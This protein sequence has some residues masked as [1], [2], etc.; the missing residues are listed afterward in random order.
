MCCQC[1]VY[2][3]EPPVL[4]A[5]RHIL[6]EREEQGFSE[7]ES[8][9]GFPGRLSGCVQMTPLTSRGRAEEKQACVV[10]SFGWVLVWVVKGYHVRTSSTLDE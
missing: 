10:S 5:P 7:G 2:G 1:Y 6:R 3:Q 8:Q 9:A 4:D